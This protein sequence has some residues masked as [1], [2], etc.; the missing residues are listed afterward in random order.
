[1]LDT[2]TIARSLTDAKLTPEQAEA[3]TAAVRQAAEHDNAAEPPATQRDLA[4]LESRL[5]WRLVGAMIAVAAIQ[6]T[7]LVAI[8]RL[9]G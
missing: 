1:M 3:I 4:E 7:A 8:L 6:T 5:T 9:M 2:L